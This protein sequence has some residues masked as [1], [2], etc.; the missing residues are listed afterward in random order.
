MRR[1]QSPGGFHRAAFKV[2]EWVM[3]AGSS[4]V[5][6]LIATGAGEGFAAVRGRCER[7]GCPTRELPPP[8]ERGASSDNRGSAGRKRSLSNVAGSMDVDTERNVLGAEADPGLWA[9]GVPD[10]C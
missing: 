5:F 8:Q 10:G 6:T 2:H 7:L 3:P 9:R 4:Q 1:V